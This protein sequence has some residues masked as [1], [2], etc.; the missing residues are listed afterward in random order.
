MNKV[1]TSN[2][3][4]KNHVQLGEKGVEVFNN[5]EF[6]SVRTVLIDGNTYFV[7]KDV[8]E[9]F[10]DTNYRRSLSNIDAYD[11]GVSQIDTPKWKQNMFLK[12]EGSFAQN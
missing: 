11:K 10:G 8:C 3:Q 12:K 1:M 5:Q 9:A 6:G 7:G 2:L 4:E